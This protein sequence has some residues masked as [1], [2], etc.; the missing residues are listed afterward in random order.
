VSDLTIALAG[1]A[2]GSIA[3]AGLGQL[4]RARAAWS[5]VELHDF[6]ADERNAQLVVWV[7]DRTRRLLIEME[8]TTNDLA[9]RGLLRSGAHANALCNLKAEALHEYRDQEWTARI[10]LA[11]LRAK[12][13]TWHSVWRIL[14]GRKAPQLTARSDVEPFLARWREPIT[15]HGSSPA[16]AASVLDRTTRTTA[17]AL[18][19]LPELKLT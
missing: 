8:G 5:E 19:E 7:D 6:E 16:D 3:T 4:G 17:D 2:I 1:G 11:R 13:G 9:A 15:R 10:D 12:E 14:R 18:S